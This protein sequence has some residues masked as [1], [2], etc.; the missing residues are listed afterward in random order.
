MQFVFCLKIYENSSFNS[1]VDFLTKQQK[2]KE[3]RKQQQPVLFIM[4][5]VVETSSLYTIEAEEGELTCA[6]CLDLYTDPT[7]LKWYGVISLLRNLI[8]CI[9]YRVITSLYF[10]QTQLL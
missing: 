4:A 8:S 3:E 6:I 7:V 9:N 1:V 10:Q 2:K 5:T